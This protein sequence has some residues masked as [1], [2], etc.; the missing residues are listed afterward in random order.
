MLLPSTDVLSSTMANTRERGITAL[1]LSDR[2]VFSSVHC[3]SNNTSSLHS[4]CSHGAVNQT[5]L[6]LYSFSISIANEMAQSA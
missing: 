1:L 4:V 5:I 2:V 3:H 6:Y